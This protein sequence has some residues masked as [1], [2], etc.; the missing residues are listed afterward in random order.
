[1]KNLLV[2]PDI[3][4]K[5]E[6]MKTK[7]IDTLQTHPTDELIFLGD[8]FDDWNQQYNPVKYK[9]TMS[10]IDNL[11]QSLSQKCVFLLGNHDYPYISKHLEY[12]SIKYP[13]ITNEIRD[14]I[15]KHNMQ[16]AYLS[17][18]ILFSHAG[19]LTKPKKW[20]FDPCHQHM[21]GLTTIYNDD[22]GPLWI[23]PYNLKSTQ[24]KDIQVFGHTPT[25]TITYYSPTLI[26]CDTWSTTSNNQPIGDNSLLHISNNNIFTIL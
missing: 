4:L 25:S 24:I 7:I 18:T 12:Y 5:F 9:N 23:R 20:H 17:N 8:Y 16:L 21:R 22:D 2:I 26:N 1:M 14:W 15:I 11:V 10:Q 3:H 19:Y 6:N 13:D